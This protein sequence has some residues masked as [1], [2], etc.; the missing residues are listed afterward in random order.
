MRSV[1]FDDYY[2]IFE[3]GF[4]FSLDR[5]ISGKHYQ[6]R[7]ITPRQNARGD[8]VHLHLSTGEDKFFSLAKLVYISFTVNEDRAKDILKLYDSLENWVVTHK[9]GDIRNNSFDNLELENKGV[10]I[11]YARAQRKDKKIKVEKEK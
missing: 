6:A 11:N 7:R 3:N 10:I 1:K 8:Q 4:V 2:V 9:D 5:I